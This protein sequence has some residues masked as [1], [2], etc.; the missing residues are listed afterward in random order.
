ML[1]QQK[2]RDTAR[3][4]S[5]LHPP[6]ATLLLH[7]KGH[8]GGL[9]WSTREQWPQAKLARRFLLPLAS[10]AAAASAAPAF[11]PPAARPQGRTFLQLQQ[12]V[13]DP[14]QQWLADGCH[15]TRDPLPAIGGAGFA[16]V[17]ALHLEVEGMGLI[18]PHVAGVARQ[19]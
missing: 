12:R 3:A 8:G 9:R 13:L 2:G 11:V 10:A 18:A 19:V 4:A 16:S 14:L 7:V 6:P 15:L 17:E 1:K 5:A